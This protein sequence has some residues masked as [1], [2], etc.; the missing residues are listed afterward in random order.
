MRR[1]QPCSCRFS[2][3]T[4]IFVGS[5]ALAIIEIG[6]KRNTSKMIQ[7]TKSLVGGTGANMEKEDKPW[8]SH[9]QTIANIM[10]ARMKE[11]G[12]TQRKLAEKMNCT[13][14]YIS[15]ILKGREN[16]SLE[17]LSKIEN[18][19]DIQILQFDN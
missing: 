8:L 14:Q 1:K 6:N 10:S 13:Q 17:A 19:L 5:M 4:I 9:S 15:K 16:L 18:A 11:L 3:K 12:M 7:E 2:E